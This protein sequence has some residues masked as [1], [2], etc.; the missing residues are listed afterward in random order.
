MGTSSRWVGLVLREHFVKLIAETLNLLQELEA[1]G[2]KKT[3]E[4]NRAKA[5]E[6]ATARLA[7]KSAPAGEV[8]INSA[9][10]DL[11]SGN[12]T[13]AS[14]A[15]ELLSTAALVA[16]RR[17]EVANELATALKDNA[18]RTAA[19]KALKVWGADKAVV[20]LLKDSRVF[21]KMEACKIL[22]E[23]GTNECPPALQAVLQDSNGSV[24]REAAVAVKAVEGRKVQPKQSHEPEKKR[25]GVGYPSMDHPTSS[26]RFGRPGFPSGGAACYNVLGTSYNVLGT[27]RLFPMREAP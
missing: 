15:A 16:G 26:H 23:I 11:K 2:L 18:L 4:E 8:D 12:K 17:D 21:V 9:L 27:R 19:S 25:R 10:A 20:P 5:L 22:A 1:A 6:A 14:N 3:E 24:R 13:K 7:A